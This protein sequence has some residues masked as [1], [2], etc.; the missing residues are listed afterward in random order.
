MAH[1]PHVAVCDEIVQTPD[2]PTEEQKATVQAGGVAFRRRQVPP[3]GRSTGGLPKVVST[4]TNPAAHGIGGPIS[5]PDVVQAVPSPRPGGIGLREST[6]GMA[7]VSRR[8]VV[9]IGDMVNGVRA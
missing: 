1:A 9:M 2:V 3:F 6:D 8:R 4:Q 7:E 5:P